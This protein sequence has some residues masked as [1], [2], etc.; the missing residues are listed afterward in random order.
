MGTAYDILETCKPPRAVFLDYPLG[1]TSGR[2]FAPDEQFAITRTAVEALAGINKPGTILPLNYVWS[3]DETWKAEA[4][5][6]DTGD[7]RQPRDLTPRY[8]FEEDRIAA[9]RLSA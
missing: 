2:P 9:E 6:A 3:D 5:V 7:K 1:N 4:A 8:Q